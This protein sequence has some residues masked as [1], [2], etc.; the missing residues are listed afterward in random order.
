DTIETELMLADLDS[1]EK[2]IPTLERR[3]RGQDTEAKKTL[4]LVERALVLLREGKPARFAQVSDEERTAFKALNLLTAKPV[5]YGCNADDASPGTGNA[6]SRRVEERAKAEGAGCV[7]I[8]AKIEAEL[9]ELSPGQR[10]GLLSAV[11]PFSP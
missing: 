6:H 11:W 3:V 4:E 8:S 2:R 10:R 1:L 9:A 7:I 5:L